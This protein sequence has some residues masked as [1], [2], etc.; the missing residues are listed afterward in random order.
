MCLKRTSQDGYRFY[1]AQKR[2]HVGF[3]ETQIAVLQ[4]LSLK[5]GLDL[6]NTVRHCVML[7][8]EKESIPIEPPARR[9]SRGR[10]I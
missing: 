9:T 6:T 4:K 1:M 2:M 5:W 7:I 3:S 8:A 10:Q